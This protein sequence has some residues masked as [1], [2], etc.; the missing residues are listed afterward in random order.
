MQDNLDTETSTDEV[1]STRKTKH[2][3]L[4]FNVYCF[5]F[6][7][8]KRRESSTHLHLIASLRMGGAVSPLLCSLH[9]D[10]FTLS[11]TLIYHALIFSESSSFT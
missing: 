7:G 5:F 6:T 1:L 10:N 2:L 8:G 4:L 11:V 3:R 9:G